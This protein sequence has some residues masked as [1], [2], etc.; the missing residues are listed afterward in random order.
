MWDSIRNSVCNC[1]LKTFLW[2]LQPRSPV[3]IG[4][5]SMKKE[6]GMAGMDDIKDYRF[7]NDDGVVSKNWHQL[8]KIRT[9]RKENHSTPIQPDREEP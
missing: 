7:K 6:S 9:S 4:L 2:L 5:K 8:D 3:K 1:V